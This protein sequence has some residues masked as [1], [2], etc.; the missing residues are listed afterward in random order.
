MGISDETKPQDIRERKEERF[1]S[2]N[3]RDSRY[4]IE[5]A[6]GISGGFSL[7]DNRNVCTGGNRVGYLSSSSG[8]IASQLISAMEIQLANNRSA[9][10][11]LETRGKEI[12]DTLSR[13]KE[14][15]QEL[16]QEQ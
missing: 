4:E 6:R 9:I 1:Y 13:L 3:D 11:E 16:E 8:G 15:Q 12:E 7:S 14:I 2:N 5:R 10:K